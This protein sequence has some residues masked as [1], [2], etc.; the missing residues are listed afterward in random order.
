[1]SVKDFFVAVVKIFAIYILIE[2][3]IPVISNIIYFNQIDDATFL[4]GF[5]GVILLFFAIVYLMLAFAA[6]IVSFL[7]LDKGFEATQFDF[8]KTDSNYIVEIVI[9]MMGVYLLFTTIPYILQDGYT[10]LKSNVNSY[11]F[12]FKSPEVLKQNLYNNLLYILV[13]IIIL[14]LRKPIA[15]IFTSKS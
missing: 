11:S 12:A 15:N 5:I 6:K 14:F 2:G 9:A 13:G 10:L 7:R 8:S 1:M 3:I 4:F